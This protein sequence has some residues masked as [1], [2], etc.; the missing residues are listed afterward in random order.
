LGTA[1]PLASLTPAWQAGH[2]LSRLDPSEHEKV[3]TL[4][5]AVAGMWNPASHLP[6]LGPV[7]G[8]A[9][10]KI[11]PDV[12]PETPKITRGTLGGDGYYLEAVLTSKG[13]GVERLI[14]TKFKAAD[15]LGRPTDRPF[16]II[17][18]DPYLASYLLYHYLPGAIRDKDNPVTTLGE[19]IWTLEG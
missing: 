5:T 16:E 18:E 2:A 1:E 7:G 8:V 19:M 13:A 14:L 17:Q 15:Y 4:A 9:Q 12:K 3:L 11:F 10:A 6:T